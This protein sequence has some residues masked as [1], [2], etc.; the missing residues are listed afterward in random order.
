MSPIRYLSTREVLSDDE[1]TWRARRSHSFSGASMPRTESPIESVRA[2]MSHSAS[3]LIAK[4]ASEVNTG[5][6]S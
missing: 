5:Q 2:A 3:P 6:A 4:D 1:L